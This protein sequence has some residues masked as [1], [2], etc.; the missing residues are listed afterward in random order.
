MIEL[1][2]DDFYFCD[3]KI[4]EQEFGSIIDESGVFGSA[5]YDGILGLSYPV[6]S[7]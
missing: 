4:A 1:G 6:L 3:L 5:S 2:K 7:D